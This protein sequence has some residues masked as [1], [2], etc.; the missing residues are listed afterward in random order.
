MAQ[1]H[2]DRWRSCL[3]CYFYNLIADDVNLSSHNKF[4]VLT[5]SVCM[6]VGPPGPTGATG[7]R[8][9]TGVRGEA[10]LNG[11]DG[12]TGARG[13]PGLPGPPGGYGPRGSTG[14]HGIT[15]EQSRCEFS[16]C[17]P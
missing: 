12:R 13:S 15:G 7:V 2:V 16:H 10:G 14:A 5:V 6:A 8:G 11:T 3:F 9:V 17:G 1:L 4:L